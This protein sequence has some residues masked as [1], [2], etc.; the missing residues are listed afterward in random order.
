[1]QPASTLEIKKPTPSVGIVILNWRGL[2]DTLACLTSLQ[3]VSYPSV[4]I[5]VVEN[6]SGDNSAQE[7]RKAFQDVIFLEQD[8]NYGYAGGNNIGI[9]YAK[10]SDFDYVLLLNND[11]EVEPVFLTHMVKVSEE[12]PFVGIAGPT[13]Y[14]FDQPDT[15]WS[16]GGRVDWVKGD[17]HM[18]GIDEPDAGQYGLDPRPVEWITGCAL[19]I[20]KQVF[21]QIGGLDE[22]FFAYY[23]EAEFCIRARRA[24]WSVVHVP[25]AKVWHKISH[26]AR[27]SSPQVHYYMSRNRLLFLK[28][29]RADFLSR[30]YALMIGFGVR[31]INW[32][33]NPKW[34]GKKLQRQAL[35]QAVVDYING[36]YGKVDIIG[37]H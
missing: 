16:A 37:K 17:T 28:L 24:G 21:E 18:I 6:G 19:L 7:I 35:K 20:K 2:A 22:R 25:T 10:E 32:L 3:K 11:V 33:I 26:R 9:Q 12:H 31:Y 8:V 34:R 30:A 5:I 13:I 29:I 23:E 1:M 14:Y 27:E 36:R 15:I 4:K